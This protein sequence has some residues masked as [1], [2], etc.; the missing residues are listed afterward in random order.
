M[1]PRANII[2][3]LVMD[4]QR[5]DVFRVRRADRLVEIVGVVE[6]TEHSGHR[7]GPREVIG[8]CLDVVA[9]LK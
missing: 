9:R 8:A 4:L 5:P 3:A 1:C 7:R 6:I 2:E